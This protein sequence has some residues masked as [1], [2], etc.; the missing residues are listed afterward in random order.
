MTW[1]YVAIGGATIASG[2]MA[3]KSASKTSSRAGASDAAS[4][5]FEKKKYADWQD[6]YGGLEDNLS[7][8]YNSLTPEFYEAQGL[9]N[10]QKEHQLEMENVRTTLAQR[11]IEDSGIA[12]A[13]E[14]SSLQQASTTRANIRT[15]APAIAAEEQRSFLQIGLGQNPGES[16]SRT[17]ANQASSQNIRA[18]SERATAGKAIGTAVTTAGTALSDYLNRP[19]TPS[20]ADAGAVSANYSTDRGGYA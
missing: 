4:I 12:L 16:Y 2:F 20:Y 9:E 14:V 6:V 19:S 8:Y 17:L 3:S 5:K 1:G 11:G 18:A 7:D 13:A 10:F 15:Q